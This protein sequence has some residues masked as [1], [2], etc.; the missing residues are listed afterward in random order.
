MGRDFS[1][2]NRGKT[3]KAWELAYIRSPE[4]EAREGFAIGDGG[5]FVGCARPKMHRGEGLGMSC[6]TALAEAEGGDEN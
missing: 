2:D 4:I 1:G 5:V 6:R 3:A